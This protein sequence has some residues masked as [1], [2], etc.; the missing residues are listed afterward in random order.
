[1]WR[2]TTSFAAGEHSGA[3]SLMAAPPTIGE[4]F[5]QNDI[6]R[7]SRAL[8]YLVGGVTAAATIF[9]SN[10]AISA[11]PHD[12]IFRAAASEAIPQKLPVVVPVAFSEALN[13]MQAYKALQPGW[14]GQGSVSPDHGLIEAASK[15]LA[16]L[17]FNL[18]APEPS[19][20]ADGSVSWFWKSDDAYATVSFTK[21]RRFAY[22]G[23]D[24][25]SGLKA[26]G[27]GITDGGIPE[28]FLQIVQSF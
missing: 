11:Q 14:D 5:A 16:T 25:V 1:M 24:R 6:V 8:S 2:D 13:E 15:F 17:P 27:S 3:L 7:S 19:V 4:F 26:K 20:S 23:V 18:S 12:L 28:D 22:Y 21:T 9:S 10:P